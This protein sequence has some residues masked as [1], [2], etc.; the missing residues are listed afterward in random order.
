MVA[1]NDDDLDPPEF[2]MTQKED[3]EPTE[4]EKEL[5]PS[6]N[7]DP[8]LLAE[9]TL[10]PMSDANDVQTLANQVLQGRWGSTESW[11]R[12]NL[13]KAGHSARAVL[14]EVK[15]LSR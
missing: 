4:E 13:N 11:Q 5:L 9:G 15:N 12:R 6:E 2:V 1:K 3:V 7:L 14:A 8:D 10:L